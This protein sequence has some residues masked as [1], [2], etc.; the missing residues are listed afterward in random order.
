MRTRKRYPLLLTSLALAVAGLPA[1]ASSAGPSIVATNTPGS[2]LYSEEHHAWTPPQVSVGTGG[3]VTLS[4]SSEV[5]HGIEW[6]SALKPTCEEGAGKVPVGTTPAASGTKWT[7]TCTFS[8]AGTYTFYCTVHGPEM[9][10]TITVRNPGEP[11]ATSE[12]ATALSETGATLHGTVNPEGHETSYFFKYGLTTNYGSVVPTTAQ[13]L[14]SPNSTEGVSAPLS[15]L[16]PGTSYHFQ[17]VAENSSGTVHG[18]D[19]TFT[20]ASPPG[21]PTATTGIATA[22]SETSATLKGTVNPDG[23]PTEYL[24]EWGLTTSYGQLTSELPAGEDHLGHAESATLTG[25]LPGTVYHFKLLAHN[26]SGPATGVDGQFTTTSPLLAPSPSPQPTTVPELGGTTTL[27]P[28]VPPAS[29]FP[30]KPEG[31]LVLGSPLVA[32]SL[33]LT[34][35]HH[36][37]SVRVSVQVAKTGAGGHLEIELLARGALLG[38]GSGSKQVVVGHLT[39]QSVASGGLSLTVVLNSRVK[40]ALTHRHSLPLTAKITFVPSHGTVQTITRSVTLRS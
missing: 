12:A 1:V 32:S 9:T 10:G 3:T 11:V 21:A 17:L 29:T 14:A 28:I 26:S 40:H 15:G 5:P 19:Q 37:S 36:G 8:Q 4:N 2:G 38:K 34:V 16:T 30:P 13:K 24:F 31:P 7:G 6:R 33:K 20:T 27:L 39:R 35:P 23:L 18:A 25:L 22:V